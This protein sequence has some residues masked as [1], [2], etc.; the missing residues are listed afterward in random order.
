M[1]IALDVMGGDDAPESTLDGALR[2][3]E[4]YSWIETIYLVGDEERMKPGVDLRAF[5][6]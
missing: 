1:K 4:D 2:A 5:P 6:A 3:L